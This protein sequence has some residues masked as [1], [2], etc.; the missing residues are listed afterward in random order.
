MAASASLTRSFRL[1]ITAMLNV[2]STDASVTILLRSIVCKYV[3]GGLHTIT[4][5]CGHTYK[6]LSKR[7]ANGRL[8]MA[9]AM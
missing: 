3:V 4:I 8:L 2:I 1:S 7:E 9:A 6:L 5:Q